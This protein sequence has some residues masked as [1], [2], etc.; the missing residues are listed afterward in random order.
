MKTFL[1][2]IIITLLELPGVIGF[3]GVLGRSIQRNASMAF[4]KNAASGVSI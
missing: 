4:I 3:P 2:S 1:K